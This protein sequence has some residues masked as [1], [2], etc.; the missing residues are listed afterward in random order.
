MKRLLTLALLGLIGFGVTSVQTDRAAA[1]VSGCIRFEPVAGSGNW[2]FW[3]N[4][5]SRVEVAY[6][7]R[8]TGDGSTRYISRFQ[9]NRGATLTVYLQNR[10]NRIRIN[11]IE[12]RFGA[13]SIPGC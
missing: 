9:F 8:Y 3:N 5:A 2:K 12:T 11:H 4:C 6:C 1:A 10:P 13:A 7:V